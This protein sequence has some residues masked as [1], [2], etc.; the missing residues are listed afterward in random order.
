M[1]AV[2]QN[3]LT[4]AAGEVVF[5]EDSPGVVGP[6]ESAFGPALFRINAVLEADITSFEDAKAELKDELA[7]EKARR[8]VVDRVTDID[9][10]LAAG[11]TIE[12]LAAE[13]EMELGTIGFNADSEEGIASYDGF[14]TAVLDAQSDDF[15]E[16][17]DLSDG[18]IFALRLDSIKDPEQIPLKAVAIEVSKN[19]KKAETQKALAAKAQELKAVVESGSSLAYLELAVVSE[20]NIARTAF[21]E[22]LPQTTVGTV[23]ELNENGVATVDGDQRVLLAVLSAINAF[24]AASSDNVEIVEQ[25]TNAVTDQISADVLQLY[26]AALQDQADVNINQAAINAVLSANGMGGSHSGN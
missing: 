10:L 26:T 21:L 23:F 2:E 14:R 25:I 3:A 18:G 16:I 13:T 6:V 1:G 8:L 22:N 15:P 5:A 17:L 12:D 19:W 9:D 11:A 7:G 4:K 20:A 24:D